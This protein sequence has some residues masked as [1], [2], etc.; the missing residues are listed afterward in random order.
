L[1]GS[2]HNRH[3]CYKNAFP[4]FRGSTIVRWRLIQQYHHLV[5]PIVSAILLL[6]SSYCVCCS[7]YSV[8]CSSYCVCGCCGQRKSRNRFGSVQ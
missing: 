6:G 4:T 2:I 3:Q 8:C 5:H 7:S 1:G